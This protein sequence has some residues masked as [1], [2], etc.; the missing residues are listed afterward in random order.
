MT[1]KEKKLLGPADAAMVAA[2]FFWA[3]GTVLTKETIGVTPG[4]IRVYVFNSLRLIIATSMLYAFIKIRGGTVSIK[5][6]HL[7]RIAFLSFYGLFFFMAV[8][9]WGLRMTSVTHA[10]VLIGTIPLFIVLISAVTGTEKPTVWIVA[11]I[12]LGFLG[13]MTFTLEDGLF[14]FNKGDVLVILSCISWSFYTVYGK[15]VLDYYSAAVTTFWIFFF[16][17]LYHIP[18]F[19]IQAHEQSWQAITGR[20]WMNVFVAAAGPLFLSN[21]LYYYSLGKIGPSRVG[22]YTNLE[23][24]FTLLLAFV[25][26]GEHITFMYIMAFAAIMVGI[27]LTKVGRNTTET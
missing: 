14:T 11:G 7:V 24:G 26:I 3:L 23:P 8:F 12:I 2:C 4:S 6:E 5:R 9:H 16:T 20:N 15:A 19:F 13:V 17:S 1:D 21:T 10:G 18:L 22:I 25:L 27:G